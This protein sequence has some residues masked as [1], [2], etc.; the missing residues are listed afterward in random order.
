MQI[1]FHSTI[2]KELKTI[3]RILYSDPD[4]CD[5]GLTAICLSLWALSEVSIHSATDELW[6]LVNTNIADIND[7]NIDW[8]H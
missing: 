8:E 6:L 4:V 3:L 1:H 5:R 7:V 2:S